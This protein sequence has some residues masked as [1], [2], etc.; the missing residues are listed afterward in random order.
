MGY[1]VFLDFL[2]N[3]GVFKSMHDVTIWCAFNSYTRAVFR[4][5]FRPGTETESTSTTVT[6]LKTGQVLGGLTLKGGS[7]RA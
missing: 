6:F 1:I 2:L 3:A 7:R 4:S 5:A